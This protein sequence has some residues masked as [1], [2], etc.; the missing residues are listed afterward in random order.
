MDIYN[1]NKYSDPELYRILEISSSASDR[2]LEA[3]ILSNIDK[4]KDERTKDGRS[5]HRF[6]TDVYDHFFEDEDD[7]ENET[8]DQNSSTNMFNRLANGLVNPV[9]KFLSNTDTET[10]QLEEGFEAGD[11]KVSSDLSTNSLPG[12][13]SINL[14]G[15][16][17]DSG[18]NINS[19]SLGPQNPYTLPPA[20]GQTNQDKSLNVGKPDTGTVAKKE[21]GKSGDP[22]YTASLSYT[23]GKL[24]PILKETI[25][26]I[27]SIDSQYRDIPVYPN[28]T[29]F[30]FNLSDTLI[31]VVSLKLY[32]VQIPYTWY[33]INGNFGANFFY[34]KGNSPGIGDG[35]AAEKYQI[36][37]PSG[38]YTQQSVITAVSSSIQ[39][40]KTTLND[41]SFGTTD[42]TYNAS[43]VKSTFIMD[44]KQ[45]FDESCYEVY[46]FNA[47]SPQDPSYN[48]L[49]VSSMLGFNNSTYNPSTVYSKTFKSPN[50]VPISPPYYDISANNP[51][52]TI[53]QQLA[54]ATYTFT[55]APTFNVFLYVPAQTSLQTHNYDYTTLQ[56]TDISFAPISLINT[57]AN[58]YIT[59]ITDP[60]NTYHYNCIT[61]T[62]TL[63]T[64]IAY[65]GNTIMSNLNTQIANNPY[66]TSD[67]KIQ[68]VYVNGTNSINVPTQ[69]STSIQRFSMNLQ[70]NRAYANL[71]NIQ[72]LKTAI[73][74]PDETYNAVTNPFPVFSD[75]TGQHSL[76]QFPS[77]ITDMSFVTLNNFKTESPALLMVYNVVSSVKCPYILAQC[78]LPGYNNNLNDYIFQF[79]NPNVQQHDLSYNTYIANFNN[80]ST[81]KLYYYSQQTTSTSGAYSNT[82]PTTD[83]VDICF[84]SMH[85]NPVTVN[86][87]NLNPQIYDISFNINRQ[88][89]NN[90]YHLSIANTGLTNQLGYVDAVS[91][92]DYHSTLYSYCLSGNIVTT[93][94]LQYNPNPPNNPLYLSNIAST[95][96]VNITYYYGPSPSQY[97]TTQCSFTD[98]TPYTDINTLLT[99][100]SSTINSKINTLYL[101]PTHTANTNIAN[102]ANIYL[103]CSYNKTAFTDTGFYNP[104]G[105]NTYRFH[106]GYT[107][108]KF[109][110]DMTPSVL[111]NDYKLASTQIGPTVTNVSNRISVVQPSASLQTFAV[112]TDAINITSN[113]VRITPDV[114]ETISLTTALA[115]SFVSYVNNVNT[116]ISHYSTS[117]SNSYKINNNGTIVLTY[118]QIPAYNSYQFNWTFDILTNISTQ[119]YKVS[120]LSSSAVAL[121]SGFSSSQ[122]TITP[123]SVAW[124]S[125]LNIWYN[126]FNM[127]TSS[128]SI[129][130][131]PSTVYPYGVPC[132]LRNNA[133]YINSTNQY[134]MVRPKPVYTGVYTNTANPVANPNPVVIPTYYYNDILYDILPA[135]APDVIYYTVDDFVAAINAATALTTNIS[136]S[137]TN[138][139]VKFQLYNTSSYAN[140]TGIVRQ[141]SRCNISVNKLYTTADYR[142]VFYD[143]NSF[144]FCNSGLSANSAQNTTWDATLGW[145]LGFRSLTE[146]YLTPQNMGQQYPG[147]TPLFYYIDTFTGT[148]Y[149]QNAYTYDPITNIVNII[150]DTSVNVSLYNYFMIILDDY[151]QNHLNDG[152][153]T[154]IS[155]ATDIALPSYTNRSSIVPSPDG[156]NI[157]NTP[158]LTQNQIYSATQIYNQQQ[159]KIKSYS[160]GPFVH[161]VFALIPVKTTGLA[162]G[163][164]YIEFGGSLQLQDRT[165]F[166]PVNIKKM[167]VKLIDDKGTVLNLNNANWSFS[168][169]CEQLYNP[170]PQK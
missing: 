150:G 160:S 87:I 1:I 121:S 136:S 52:T 24:N 107:L 109:Q 66:F 122:S 93:S 90:D 13:G 138:I 20:K 117:V 80:N 58:T 157:V 47:A 98:L 137:N 161:D 108:P 131:S 67:S 61:I 75:Q 164:T 8:Q 30:S 34:I 104:N 166:G 89:Y 146:Y 100:L 143:S 120:F 102:T 142:L 101:N 149:T 46:F 125:S 3:K 31:D 156:S 119:N 71:N 26:R 2:E 92:A 141:Y 38:N 151:C 133:I 82:I 91:F 51:T 154:I 49:S 23:K 60:T 170:N 69:I 65:S 32:S 10:P 4:Y 55:V 147:L 153:V 168:L 152:L 163:S 132:N 59:Y 15:G 140:S 39:T 135:G 159:A 78:Q 72:G 113:N 115:S 167:T 7:A 19:L 148:L 68:T 126:Y 37:V 139:N 53:S 118:T 62:S 36:L 84:N 43:T 56:F 22:N 9:L 14:A 105:T 123:Q 21:V 129:S 29:S 12:G 144:I 145:L 44:I 124:D 33:T 95:S 64:G 83:R 28:T 70:L 111:F 169:V 77:P 57:P 74:F 114:S 134:F 5:I 16:K 85:T 128:S 79:P 155:A 27:I 110:V 25:K 130:L 116:S 112:T 50:P 11:L 40:L 41:I 17:T 18:A 94:N 45:I 81:N 97:I 96:A 76:F 54:N 6:F 73:Q 42:I 88:F 35:D 106:M 86:S 63:A 162:A 158:G 165:Y 99:Y 48:L 127:P 103:D